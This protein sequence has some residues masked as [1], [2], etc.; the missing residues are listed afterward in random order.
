MES[1][2]KYQARCTPPK[3][4]PARPKVFNKSE[5]AAAVGKPFD[6]ERA[7][8]NDFRCAANIIFMAKGWSGVPI[9][10]ILFHWV[11]GIFD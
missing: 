3:V 5:V 8:G 6:R 2:S 9:K 11:N 4:I 10:H 7:F 1:I